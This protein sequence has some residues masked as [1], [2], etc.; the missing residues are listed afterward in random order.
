[1]DP[2][3]FAQSA[4]DALA[5]GSGWAGAG[6]LG[7]V[8]SW[9]FLVH[10]PSKDKQLKETMAEHR[11]ELAQQRSDFKVNLD[12]IAEHCE[13][14]MKHVTDTFYSAIRDLKDTINGKKPTA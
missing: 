9:V 11:N 10:L 1:M 8:L 12:R 3:V 4:P 5:G 13:S 7:L 6:L 14:E 2:L